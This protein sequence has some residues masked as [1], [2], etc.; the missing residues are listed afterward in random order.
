MHLFPINWIKPKSGHLFFFIA[1]FAWLMRVAFILAFPE[2][3]SPAHMDSGTY[4]SIAVNLIQ[5]NGYS[6]DGLNPSI[7][8]APGLPFLLAAV[9]RLIGVHPMAIDFIFSLLGIGIGVWV[10]LL[11]RRLF[12]GTV[13]WVAFILTLLLPDLF[14][15]VTFLYTETLFIFF[16]L[17]EF[18]LLYRLLEH[19]SPGRAALAGLVGGM[20]TLIRG[21]TLWLPLLL[22]PILIIY[23]GYKRALQSVVL[24]VVFMSIPILPWMYRNIRTFDA[25][26][27][28]A[29][30]TGDVLWTGN[31][32][33]HDGKYSYDKTMAVMDSIAAG[34]NQV[35]R[36]ERLLAE[37]KRHMAQNPSATARLLVKKFF[38]F[39]F[40]VYE[41]TP[42]GT[43]RNT[44]SM[45]RIVLSLGYYPLLI[46]F[47]FGLWLSRRRW[48]QLLLL[49]LFCA[50]Y[51][52][53]HV[54]TL[55]VPRYRIPILPIM[56]IFAAVTIVF[57]YNFWRG[58]SA[59]EM[60]LGTSR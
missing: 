58:K 51:T 26:V 59:V 11:A 52:A 13:A 49:Y 7:F 9:Y 45:T 4:H 25:M 31:Y 29:V 17:F 55:V 41:A 18:W 54:L 1:L 38:R 23:F 35:Q 10:F 56:A 40:W 5:G 15:I 44:H 8:V 42:G 32:L 50:Y 37:A 39:W 43:V 27:P 6:E 3:G 53:I 46:L 28:V 57:L 33:P 24:F 16:L 30:G 12:G 20:V 60:N 48:R 19:P 14:V 47:L 36:E 21:V 2:L 22:L 34:L